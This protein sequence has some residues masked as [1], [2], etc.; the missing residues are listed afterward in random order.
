MNSEHLKDA[1]PWIVRRDGLDKPIAQSRITKEDWKRIL[2][3]LPKK[4]T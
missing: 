1:N 4:K 3:N 2:S